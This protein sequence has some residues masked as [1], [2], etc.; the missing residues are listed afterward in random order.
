MEDT[1]SKQ[2]KNIDNIKLSEIVE[3][4]PPSGIRKFFSLAATMKG[5]ISLGIG[6]PDYVTPWHIRE[7]AIYSLENG[8]TMYTANEGIMELR[9]EI[10]S[11]IDY[12]YGVK[13]NPETEILITVGTSEALDLALRAIINPGD[14]VIIPDPCYVAYPAC[15]ALAGA[16]PVT[17]PT[18]E[19]NDFSL[20]ASD[21][22]SRITSK[23]KA[24]I[25]GN[26]ANPTGATVGREELVEIGKLALKH[27]I[28]II[29]DEIYERLVYNEEHICFPSLKQMKDQTILINGFS[30]AY[31]MTGWRVGYVAANP[32][33]AHAMTKIHQYTMLCASITAQLSAIEALKRGMPEVKS[34]VSDYGQRRRVM[35]NGFREI[36]LSCFD[37]RGAFYTFPSIK[38]TGLSSEEFS[39]RLLE[40]EKVAVVPGNVFGACGEGYVRCCYA[41]SLNDIKEAIK[42]IGRFID[43]LKT[44]RSR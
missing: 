20:K 13:Y 18:Y 6:E 3:K 25:I 37:P 11:H 5:V 41:T 19:A 44:G 10:S 42:R 34:M 32:R 28:I 24:I 40:K 39:T 16:K 14:E 38:S 12:Y 35:V 33:I 21:V 36:G 26:P 8:S 2:N 43:S 27:N 29:S 7:S 4:I 23:T 17:V 22:K 15:V 31:A 1:L 9:Q 30:K